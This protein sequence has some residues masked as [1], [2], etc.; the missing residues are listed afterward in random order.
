MEQGVALCTSTLRVKEGEPHV[1][2]IEKGSRRK[3]RKESPG[4][5]KGEEGGKAAITH[6][7]CWL[8][9]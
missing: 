3:R 4:G 6:W 5:K 9:R 7:L 1:E 2:P 8:G